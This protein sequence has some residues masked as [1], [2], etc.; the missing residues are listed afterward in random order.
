[1][2][3]GA[4]ERTYLLA[5]PKETSRTPIVLYLHGSSQNADGARG[6][7]A[8]A[9]ERFGALV[10]YPDGY[11]R[12]W[13]DARR[14]IPFATRKAGIDD[15]AF[16]QAVVDRLV[17]HGGD[18]SRVYL[19][20]YSNGGHMIIRLIHEIPDRFA[21]VAII[22][23]TQPEEQNFVPAARRTDPLPVLLINGTKDPL[24]PYAGGVTSM[25]GFF[26]RGRHVSAADTAAYYARRNGI[27][28]APRHN[29]VSAGRLPV[30]RLEYPY[31]EHPVVLYTVHGGGHTIPGT[32]RALP[33]LGRTAMDF[34]APAV[35]ADFFG[36]R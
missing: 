16:I 17:D 21:G 9:F 23:A 19:V 31:D 22:A 34:D 24:V 13:N 36:L 32:K 35:I 20:G 30:E 12:H 7:T 8:N 1:M 3:A 15:V 14:D 10:A 2:R 5:R 29:S 11:R 4:M 28:A 6:F 26:P 33:I 18:P 25:W 27:T